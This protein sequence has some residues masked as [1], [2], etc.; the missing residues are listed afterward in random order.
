MRQCIKNV[1]HHLLQ[2][3]ERV[4]ATTHPSITLFPS[5]LHHIARVSPAGTPSLAA[6]ICPAEDSRAGICCTLLP[7]Q[8]SAIRRVVTKA[9]DVVV[10]CDEE[11]IVELHTGHGL[12]VH[13]LSCCTSECG[14]LD[15]ACRTPVAI[16]FNASR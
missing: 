6:R 8:C 10:V 4:K 15:Q 7:P 16:L 3:N 1:L 11:V 9:A 13:A 14:A 2:L 5:S 12:V